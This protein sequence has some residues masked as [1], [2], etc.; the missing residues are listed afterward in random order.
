MGLIE[1]ISGW[2]A[3]LKLPGRVVFGLFLF[4]ALLLMLDYAGVVV[5]GAI[6][7]LAWPV[8]FIGLLL[9]GCL[10][11]GAAGG[12]GYEALKRSGAERRVLRRHR[13]RRDEREA[14]SSPTASEQISNR[15]G[16][17][18]MTPISPASR[19]HT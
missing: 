15:S 4:C 7:R 3:A 5:L 8:T 11:L 14:A 13:R 9:F 12:E 1:V 18:S 19:A 2:L 17:R 16:V 6:H 10:S